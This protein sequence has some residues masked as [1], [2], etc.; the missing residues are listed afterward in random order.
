VMTSVNSE[1]FFPSKSFLSIG[2]KRIYEFITESEL[3]C[4]T[5]GWGKALNLTP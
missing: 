3:A 4:I 5:L 2:K 1:K